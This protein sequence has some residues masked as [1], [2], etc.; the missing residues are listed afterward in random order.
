LL[1]W[2]TW[3]THRFVAEQDLRL[4]IKLSLWILMRIWSNQYVKCIHQQNVN[5]SGSNAQ[6]SQILR[7]TSPVLLSTAWCSQSSLELSM[8]LTD[9]VRAFSGCYKIW[10]IGWSNFG[11]P[12]TSAQICGRL[13]EKQ[14]P[15]CGTVGGLV[16]YSHSN[17]S[18]TTTRHFVFVIVTTFATS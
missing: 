11:A 4:Y 6:S 9:S 3:K 13:R 14:R 10:L 16:P 7:V 12:E 15:L 1:F 2:S 17:G 18:Y 5:Q 8:V